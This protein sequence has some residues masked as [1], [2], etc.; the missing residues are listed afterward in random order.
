MIALGI[1]YGT[2]NSLITEFSTNMS[3]KSV[4][5][6]LASS[7]VADVR[8]P[9]RMLND[10]DSIDQEQVSRYVRCCVGTL[11]KSL[12]NEWTGHNRSADPEMSIAITIPNSFKDTQCVFL[13]NAI[14]K[15]FA[16]EFP[17]IASSFPLHFIPEPV[18]AALY[19]AYCL[20]A[21]NVSGITYV[22][23]SDIGGGTTDLAVVKVEINQ[24]NLSFKVIG[25]PQHACA[26]GGDDIDKNLACYLS[27][28]YD[29]DGVVKESEL[30]AASRFFKER[31]SSE[32]QCRQGIL[33]QD[34]SLYSTP[35]G[36]DL[37]I[38]LSRNDLEQ[39]VLSG[40]YGDVNFMETYI[41]LLNRLSRSLRSVLSGEE[42]YSDIDYALRA[43]CILLPVGGSSRIPA[44][45]KAMQSV[46]P[47]TPIF[48]LNTE[49]DNDNSDRTKYDSVC[50]GAAIYAA[51]N[52]NAGML[53]SFCKHITIEGR[54]PHRIS[55]R[56]AYEK[57]FTIVNKTMKDDIYECHLEPKYL[58]R[59]GKTFAINKLEFYQG[60]QCDE[61]D[62]DCV[63]IKSIENHD[64][65]QTGGR[66][67]KEIT[68]IMKVKI[69]G[70]R[71]DYVTFEV[72]D[73]CGKGKPYFK[74]YG[75]LNQ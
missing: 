56:Y 3:S 70:G 52:A 57:V 14:Q 43:K 63:L 34:G 31:L 1:D 47:N 39:Y 64:P 24:D 66:S 8:S 75:G 73:G 28:K 51:C 30:L 2:T 19:Y 40:Q 16:D 9:K 35:S 65:I 20:R 29:L 27:S 74:Q 10:L 49:D 15:A 44:V 41:E 18:A 54:T 60:G 33:K 69:T 25:T 17:G 67:I 58:S 11:I 48:T 36:T 42:G 32:S 6:V 22:I 71:L 7:A 13:R 68:I 59:D 50:R 45:Q 62:Q 23:V 46:F 72:E 53:A 4:V 12:L 38:S 26:L 55:I 21:N 37:V 5:S 61:I